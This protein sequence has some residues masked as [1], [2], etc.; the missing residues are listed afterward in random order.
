METGTGFQHVCT[1]PV[2]EQVIDPLVLYVSGGFD[3]N[4]PV[5]EQLKTMFPEATDYHLKKCQAKK[6][7]IRG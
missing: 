4:T 3:R 1:F 7:F 5:E 2:T 6:K